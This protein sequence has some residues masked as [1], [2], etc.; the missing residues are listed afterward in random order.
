MKTY[1]MIA[2]MPVDY[3]SCFGEYGLSAEGVEKFN[4]LISV[5]LP[6]EVQWCGDELIA[7]ADS[8][9]E[10]DIDEIVS[11]AADEMMERYTDDMYWEV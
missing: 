7:P 11:D 5:R 2:N 8:Q 1:M 6:E 4:E 10:I 9:V 3:T